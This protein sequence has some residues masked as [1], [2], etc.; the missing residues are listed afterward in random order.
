MKHTLLPLCIC[1]VYVKNAD[2]HDALGSPSLSSGAIDDNEK[3]GEAPLL[4]VT[5]LLSDSIDSGD[6]SPKALSNFWDNVVDRRVKKCFKQ[7]KGLY[8]LKDVRFSGEKIT[9]IPIGLAC[10]IACERSTTIGLTIRGAQDI[11]VVRKKLFRYWKRVIPDKN[12]VER[13]SH[14]FDAC[15]T[16]D[17]SLQAGNVK[18]VLTDRIDKGTAKECKSV[19]RLSTC[20]Y[21]YITKCDPEASEKKMLEILLKLGESFKK[22]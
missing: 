18:F 6:V 14:L 9:Q 12:G 20:T 13:N 15:T 19:Y 5:N 11:T 22:T 8:D 3:I 10:L 7:F 2:L 16:I 17:P 1:I 21:D 4:D